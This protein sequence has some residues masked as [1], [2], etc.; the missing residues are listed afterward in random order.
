MEYYQH[1]YTIGREIKDI[2]AILC[3][4]SNNNQKLFI[5]ESIALH[6]HSDNIYSFVLNCVST[7]MGKDYAKGES[8]IFGPIQKYEQNFLKKEKIKQIDHCCSILNLSNVPQYF[9]GEFQSDFSK[10]G[11]SDNYINNPKNIE[12][13][14]II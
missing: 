3:I 4:C 9:Y 11:R 1:A 7:Y 10:Y 8:Y 13:S 5:D 12:I 14:K 6:N 2:F